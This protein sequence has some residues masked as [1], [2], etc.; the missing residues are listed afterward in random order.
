MARRARNTEPEWAVTAAALGVT[1]DGRRPS[2]DDARCMH[3]LSTPAPGRERI[4]GLVAQA[5]R[6]PS[7]HNSQPWLFTVADDTV[8]V[9]ADRTR[10]LPVNDPWDRE[11]TISCGAAVLTL[12]AAARGA[13]LLAELEP[14]PDGPEGDRIARLT[15]H[16]ADEAPIADRQLAAAIGRR[17]TV[18][19]PF[20]DRPLPPALPEMLR[21][22]AESEGALLHAVDGNQ[23]RVQL[24]ELVR[25]GD[26]LQYHDPH[27]RREL[28]A[29]MHPRRRGDGLPVP[30]GTGLLSRAVVAGADL[31]GRVGD[32][33]VALLASAP[34]VV[35]LC[36][37]GD[38]PEDW[39]VAGQALA[40]ML[41]VAAAE[42]V[43]A[44]YFNQPCQ[45]ASLRPRLR[46]LA[47]GGMPQIV[48]RFG[49]PEAGNRVDLTP[50]RPVGDVVERT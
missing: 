25:Q 11:L 20:T 48:L 40:R 32:H 7:T 42:G 39:V 6:A 21:E 44:G 47:G 10:A 46:L 23:E 26:A 19:G 17:R 14:L 37:T 31:G 24:A 16:R 2:R 41:L 27:W 18:R 50:R 43:Q 29:W 5:V 45:V 4:I 34:H 28:A 22:A 33:D 3:V 9:I 8:D 15:V 35:V 13:G 49:V 30:V 12:R 1:P 38:G 36:T